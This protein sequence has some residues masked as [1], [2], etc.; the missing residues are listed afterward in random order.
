MAVP[1]GG[2]GERGGGAGAVIAGVVS[3][4]LSLVS[5]FFGVLVALV[6]VVL[7][8]NGR[9]RWRA[10]VGD[11]R[12]ATAGLAAGILGLVVGGVFLGLAFAF[13]AHHESQIT[14]LHRCLSAAH[15]DSARQRCEQRFAKATGGG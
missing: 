14:E 9:R 10:G 6:A 2:H 1:A 12:L 5:P 11:G 7:G 4:P 13:V 3:I 8:L 15:D